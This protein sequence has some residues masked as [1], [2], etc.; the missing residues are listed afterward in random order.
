MDTVMIGIQAAMITSAPGGTDMM[1]IPADGES[2]SA[3]LASTAASAVT[4]GTEGQVPANGQ[5]SAE[6]QS[7]IAEDGY[8]VPENLP[9]GG[10]MLT[11]ALK[12]MEGL[13]KAIRDSLR[14]LLKR[15]IDSFK[16]SQDGTERKTDLF[17]VI[18]VSRE[19]FGDIL[20]PG[21]ILE[22]ISDMDLLGAEILNGL[23]EEIEE[24]I[25]EDTDD[26][27]VIEETLYK[28]VDGVVEVVSEILEDEN[29]IDESIAE[30]AVASL[31]G[32]PD[33]ESFALEAPEVQTEY[34]QR[35]AEAFKAP[36]EAINETAPEK[37]PEAEKL[38]SEFA[39]EI[40]VKAEAEVKTGNV[41]ET[42]ASVKTGFAAYRVNDAGKQINAISEKASV[43]EE[44][45][46]DIPEA[47]A[48]TVKVSWENSETVTA[49]RTVISDNITPASADETDRK[50]EI[51]VEAAAVTAAPVHTERADVPETEPVREISYKS[52]DIQVRETILAEIS[53]IPEGD[54]VKELVLILRPKELGQ[55]AVKLTKE[56]GVLSV[57]LSA[58]YNEV[59]RMLADRAAQLGNTLQSENVK[60]GSVN[61]V[62]PGSAAEQMGLNFTDRG[63]G[64]AGNQSGTGNSYRGSGSAEDQ[65]AETEDIEIIKEVRSWTT[66]A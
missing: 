58:Q 20:T 14:M 1:G 43:P 52:A 48:E 4:N 57:I 56:N 10:N 60:V 23:G 40:T 38:Y 42:A 34:V 63:F 17:A 29:D 55:V 59:G 53:D 5:L 51:A 3:V 25:P 11:E 36:M 66:I 7:P 64:F 39:A 28:I 49:E 44:I 6:T 19:D 47:A 18:F 16:G 32:I 35:I 30:E 54:A 15:V 8:A 65:Q 31:M 62:E 46:E 2:F 37:V 24:F 61:V 9:A 12:N 45:S 26:S 41:S 33:L 50:P 13:D 21:S 22:D 27:E